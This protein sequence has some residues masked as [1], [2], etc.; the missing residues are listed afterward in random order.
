MPQ[1]DKLLEYMMVDPLAV[2]VEQW[3]RQ[4]KDLD[5]QV[6]VVRRDMQV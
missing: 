3:I 6:E 4:Q 2:L 5:H 1:A